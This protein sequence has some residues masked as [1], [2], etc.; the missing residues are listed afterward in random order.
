MWEKTAEFWSARDTWTSGWIATQALKSK[1]KSSYGSKFNR[2]QTLVTKKIQWTKKAPEYLTKYPHLAQNPGFT[3]QV[4]SAPLALGQLWS[5]LPTALADAF[6][7]LMAQVMM[8]ALNE[9]PISSGLSKSELDISYSQAGD[10]FLVDLRCDAPYTTF[11]KGQ[12]AKKYLETPGKAAANTA[13]LQAM[14]SLGGTP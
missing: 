9:W 3:I 11:I 13:A 6:D 7:P 12:P 10:S 2:R 8:N 14:A 1:G 5:G 4:K